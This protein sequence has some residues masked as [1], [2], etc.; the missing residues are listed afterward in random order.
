[1]KKIFTILIGGLCLTMTAS[2]A[3]A[4][5]DEMAALERQFRQLPIEAR[6][7]TGPLFWLHGDESRARLEA[8]VAK[9]AEGGNGCF[10]AESRPH[11]DWLGPGWYR[12]LGICLAAAKKHNL[13]MWIFDERWWPSQGMGGKVPPRWAAKRLVAVATD[14][15]GPR[16]F[17]ADGYGVGQVGN[18]SYESY[19]AAIAGRVTADGRIDGNTLVDLAGSIKDGSARLGR[20]RGQ[21]ADHEVHPRAS[22]AARPEQTTERRRGQQ[23]LRGLVH[24]DRLSAALRPLQGRLRQD[25]RGLFLRRAG[26]AGRLGDRAERGPGPARR[27]LEEG[28]RGLQVRAG[29]R[30]ADRREV[31]ISRS[32]SPTPGGGRCTAALPTGATSTACGRSA[33]SWSTAT[34]TAI[35]TTAPAT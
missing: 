34:C 1:M 3:V 31:S 16:Q 27:R 14:V 24:Q 22:A 11:K 18:L 29:R 9:V 12:D 7:L 5:E 4:G 8:Y 20:A 10:T 30:G 32:A 26:D 35:R 28:L 21:V 17:K 2:A 15:E 6:R 25:D 19:V 33:I 13:K 23:R